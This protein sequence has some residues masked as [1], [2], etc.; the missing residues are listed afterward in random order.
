MNWYR[1]AGRT[2]C[3]LPSCPCSRIRADRQTRRLA[4]FIPGLGKL[5][6]L[7]L[8][9]RSRSSR[10]VSPSWSATSSPILRVYNFYWPAKFVPRSCRTYRR[11][12]DTKLGPSLSERSLGGP[13]NHHSSERRP[14]IWTWNNPGGKILLS[15]TVTV[16]S[17]LQIRRLARLS[18]PAFSFR[19]G[20]G[21][22]GHAE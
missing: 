16:I 11:A 6:R 10:E 8:C 15:D 13:D 4:A 20:N 14:P 9:I 2:S 21:R 18:S 17:S 19:G 5:C 3:L 7:S 12:T 22:Y 1:T